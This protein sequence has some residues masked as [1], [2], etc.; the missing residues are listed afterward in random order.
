MKK[1]TIIAL[2]ALFAVSASAQD[3][4]K[5][6]KKMKTTEEVEQAIKAN[7]S[8]M[9]DQEKAECYN[10]LA[11][12]YNKMVNDHV[13]KN[14][15]NTI[16]QKPLI[17][18]DENFYNAAYKALEAGIEC[19]KYDQL[20]NLKGKVA[21]KFKEIGKD[22]FQNRGHVLNGG[23]FF[24][25][26]NDI[27]ATIKYF[28]AFIGTR[29]SEI[30][31]VVPAEQKAPLDQNLAQI[32]YF[33]AYY[34]MQ[35]DM[36]L[37][38]VNKYADI[39]IA[40]KDEKYAKDAQTLKN[41]YAAKGLKTHEDSVAYAD[42]LEAMYNEDPTNVQNFQTLAM[43]RLG[44]N[45]AEKFYD[46]CQKRIDA[47]PDDHIAYYFRG[48]IRC[49]IH[50]YQNALPDLEKADQLKPND[51]GINAFIGQCWMGRA[52]EAENR[53]AGKSGIIPVTAKSQI[54][55]VWTKALDYLNKAKQLDTDG[56]NERNYK[57]KI[58]QVEYHLE[59]DY[60]NVQ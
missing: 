1:L 44:L 23:V 53:A 34:G 13:T 16:M 45:E 50:D 43:I 42:K 33:T 9:S 35:Q 7:L 51:A 40:S 2:T 15:E 8:T 59:N 57:S 11:V 55:P 24:S 20:P 29:D 19:Y 28:E 39:A 21:P 3:V 25:E 60:K 49:L 6:V 10:K 31:N 36:G 37:D 48:Q 14:Q 47:M 4:F 32:A 30:F 54:K 41:S 12:M 5:Q 27:P 22:L 52:E 56:S 17:P 26:K 38:F 58:S 18:E 46:V